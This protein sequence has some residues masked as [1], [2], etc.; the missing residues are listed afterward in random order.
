[1][2]NSSESVTTSYVSTLVH[3]KV[4][5]LLDLFTGTKIEDKWIPFTLNARNLMIRCDEKGPLIGVEISTQK[6]IVFFRSEKL[7]GKFL[8]TNANIPL[9]VEETLC[10]NGELA[11]FLLQLILTGAPGDSKLQKMFS[12]LVLKEQQAYAMKQGEWFC[13]PEQFTNAFKELILP[14]LLTTTESSLASANDLLTEWGCSIRFMTED[15]WKARDLSLKQEG[16]TF[17]TFVTKGMK[18]RGYRMYNPTLPGGAVSIRGTTKV[19]WKCDVPSWD[20]NKNSVMELVLLTRATPEWQMSVMNNFPT[21]VEFCHLSP[22][23]NYF[24]AKYDSNMPNEASGKDYQGNYLT[25]L[26]MMSQADI[27]ARILRLCEELKLNAS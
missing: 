5:K 18:R 3:E 8:D 16:E 26:L 23:D 27:G 9:Y 25:N 10:S 24:A 22:F 2:S 15:I 11:L 13:T 14:D 7:F 4:N 12:N 17:D 6:I 21:D 1:M 20:T 19:F